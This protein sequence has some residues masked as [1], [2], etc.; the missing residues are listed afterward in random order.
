MRAGKCILL[1]DDDKTSNFI[2]AKLLRNVYPHLEIIDFISVEEGLVYLK[3]AQIEHK[4][5]DLI[6][7]DINLP[8]LDGWDFLKELR[9]Q[10]IANFKSLVMLSSSIDESDLEKTKSFPEISGFMSKPLNV[11]ELNYYLNT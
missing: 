3:N 9:S 4:I 2:N 6:L 5:I 11:G 8:E 7:L 1:V 10:K